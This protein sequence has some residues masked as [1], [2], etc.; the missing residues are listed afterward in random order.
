MVISFRSG[1][2][3]FLSP[4][5]VILALAHSRRLMSRRGMDENEMNG[6]KVL[7]E[8]RAGTH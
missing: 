5:T 4:T 3:A 8:R 6:M 2:V 1:I 7:V